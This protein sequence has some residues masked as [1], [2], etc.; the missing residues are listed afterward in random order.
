[1]HMQDKEH[2]VINSTLRNA[3]ERFLEGRA[4]RSGPEAENFTFDTLVALIERHKDNMVMRENL[5]KREKE[6]ADQ[7]A[8]LFKKHCPNQ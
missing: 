3:L 6:L 4:H 1:M 5:S 2:G 8:A 7:R